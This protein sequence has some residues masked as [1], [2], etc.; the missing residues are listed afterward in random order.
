[1]AST[2][3]NTPIPSLP[4]ASHRRALPLFMSM[5]AVPGTVLDPTETWVGSTARATSSELVGSFGW[6]VGAGPP[7]SVL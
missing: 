7:V 4:V 1:M 2:L 3:A 6:P 5:K